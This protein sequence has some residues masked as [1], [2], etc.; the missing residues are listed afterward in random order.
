MFHLY[1]KPFNLNCESKR[2]WANCHVFF[3]KVLTIEDICLNFS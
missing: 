2:Q 3:T 1:L